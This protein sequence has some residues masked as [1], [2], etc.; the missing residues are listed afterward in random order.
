[1]LSMEQEDELMER[2]KGDHLRA[3]P[4]EK[5]E[6]ICLHLKHEQEFRYLAPL[7]T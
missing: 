6:E 4:S 2:A 1:M 5:K 3:W 7:D